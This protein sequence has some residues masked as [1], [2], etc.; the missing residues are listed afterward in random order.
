M[1]SVLESLNGALRRA[2]EEDPRVLLL[3]EDIVDP[4]G[5]AFKVTR[6]LSSA[7]PGRVL[8]TPVS[9]AGM[10]GVAAGMALRGFRPVVEVMFG[11]FLT[12]MADQIINHASKLGWMYAGAVSLPLVVRAPMGGR[13][14]YGP[15]HSQSLEKHFLG[16]PGL[17]V[18]AAGP[19]P[20]GAGDPGSLLHAAIRA[21]QPVLFVEHKLLY[22]LAL[23]DGDRLAELDFTPAGADAYRLSLRAA[24]APA[25]TI[26]AYGYMAELAREAIVRLAYEREIFC[27]LVIF[28]RLSPFDPQPLLESVRRTRRL[29]SVEEGTRSLGWGAGVLAAAAEGG[30]PLLAARRLAALDLPVPASPALE[31]AVLPDVDAIIQAAQKMV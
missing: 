12:L 11:D 25:L 15:T 7:F 1:T 24:P 20:I 28:T 22:P 29:L 9:E 13:R 30:L 26:A 5:G 10:M 23:W 4:Y 27:E 19:L 6:G 16:V 31:K 2:L 21:D 18:L 14:G 3:G 8:A 17:T